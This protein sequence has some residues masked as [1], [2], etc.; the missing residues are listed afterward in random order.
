MTRLPISVSAATFSILG[1][2]IGAGF[3]SGREILTF[4]GAYGYFGIGFSF[5]FILLCGAGIY[6]LLVLGSRHSSLPQL[7]KF[8]YKRAAPVAD[9]LFLFC[10]FV[11]FSSMLAGMQVTCQNMF[12][13]WFYLFLLLFIFVAL[14]FGI[15]SL[16]K[17]NNLFL[18]L[19][20]VFLFVCSVISIKNGHLH[21]QTTAS[22]AFSGASS[23]LYTGMNLLTS[24]SVLLSL[25]AGTNKKDHKK[26]AII[27]TLL[28]GVLFILLLFGLLS[29]PADAQSAPMPLLYMLNGNFSFFAN[30][31]LAVATFT[32]LLSCGYPLVQFSSSFVKNKWLASLLVLVP[33]VLLSTIGFSNIVSFLYPAMGVVGVVYLLFVAC[34]IKRKLSPK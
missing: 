16:L 8:V 1:T 13:D 18:P 31:F 17:V 28:I 2:L 14:S 19:L 24:C 7:N 10:Y 15:N 23:L 21:V 12:G 29:L 34:S 5:L 20:L 11:V 30:F 22:P 3:A 33:A 6:L 26:I 4:F 27:S 25:G 32:T 9:T